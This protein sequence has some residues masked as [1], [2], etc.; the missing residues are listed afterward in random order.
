MYILSSLTYDN[1]LLQSLEGVPS[2]ITDDPLSYTTMD[3]IQNQAPNS[4]YTRITVFNPHSIELTNDDIERSFLHNNISGINRRKHRTITIKGIIKG[5][6][7]GGMEKGIRHIMSVYRLSDT[8]HIQSRGVYKLQWKTYE[9]DTLGLPYTYFCYGYIYDFKPTILLDMENRHTCSYTVSIRCTDSYI[10]EGSSYTSFTVSEGHIAGILPYQSYALN[11]A[12]HDIWMPTMYTY[13][14]LMRDAITPLYITI[15]A[16]NNYQC[17]LELPPHTP[18]I[19]IHGDIIGNYITLAH[20]ESGLFIRLNTPITQ[21]D[22]ITIDGLTGT[23]MMNNTVS[24]GLLD[25][26]STGIPTLQAGT[27]TFVLAD[28]TH[29]RDHGYGIEALISYYPIAL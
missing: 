22:S 28:N 4:Y 19:H 12:S 9:K 8:P 18:N 27:N 20:L 6:D 7:S 23:I 21:H 29:L 11:T 3:N 14:T 26:I 24:M 13:N 1:R 16:I 15:R 17:T 5:N 10:Y 2:N 25:S